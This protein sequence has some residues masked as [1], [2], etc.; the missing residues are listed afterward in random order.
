MGWAP[1]ERKAV[2]PSK[3][4]AFSTALYVAAPVTVAGQE[5]RASGTVDEAGGA[6]KV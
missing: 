1:R 3:S 5:P 2:V 4:S 6:A